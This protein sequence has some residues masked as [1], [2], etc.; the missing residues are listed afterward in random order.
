MNKYKMILN[1]GPMGPIQKIIKVVIT[2]SVMAWR[3]ILLIVARLH[4]YR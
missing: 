4:I 2:C 1:S 3:C